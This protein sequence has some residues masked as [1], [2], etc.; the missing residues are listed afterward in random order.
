MVNDTVKRST[1][2]LVTYQRH[3]QYWLEDGSLILLSFH[4]LYKVHKTLLLRHSPT[5]AKWENR[6]HIEL[7]IVDEHL[8]PEIAEC[9]HI[10]IPDDIGLRNEDLEA[11]LE[12]LYHDV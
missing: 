3:S 9:T 2:G 11:L 6:C 10:T 4:N 7:S 8:L 5:L 12:H 1:N